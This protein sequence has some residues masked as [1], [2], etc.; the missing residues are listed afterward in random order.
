MVPCQQQQRPRFS[1]MRSDTRRQCKKQ[2]RQS[3]SDGSSAL[4]ADKGH[5]APVKRVSEIGL[6]SGGGRLE[7]TTTPVVQCKVRC[8]Q[9]F[10][11][12]L[13]LLRHVNPPIVFALCPRDNKLSPIH[14]QHLTLKITHRELHLPTAHTSCPTSQFQLLLL[15]CA[16]ITVISH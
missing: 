15:A 16:L 6:D 2:D 1:P 13:D 7:K 10:G 14:T 12:A 5:D 11:S 3:R 4:Q 8:S 9:P